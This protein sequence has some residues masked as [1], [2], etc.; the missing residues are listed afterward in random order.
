LLVKRAK[1]D[2]GMFCL[3]NESAWLVIATI[4]ELDASCADAFPAHKSTDHISWV[5]GWKVEGFETSWKCNKLNFMD[6]GQVQRE[7]A[8]SAVW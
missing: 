1:N 3:S 8:D 5:E 2:G 4:F 6:D 7:L